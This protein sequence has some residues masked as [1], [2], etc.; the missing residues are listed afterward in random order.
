MEICSAQVSITSAIIAPGEHGIC[1]SHVALSY[2]GCLNA[3]RSK[4][5]HHISIS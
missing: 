3:M 4:H 5:I 2:L 1:A